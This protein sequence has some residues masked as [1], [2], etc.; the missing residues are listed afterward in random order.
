MLRTL[1][2]MGLFDRR[3]NKNSI[4]NYRE[5]LQEHQRAEAGIL[6]D[7]GALAYEK[8]DI[9]LSL[10]CLKKSFK[11]YQELVDAEK[12]ASILDI[13]GDIYYQIDDTQNALKYYKECFDLYSSMESPNKKNIYEKIVN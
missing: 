5:K 3:K 9:E 8:D 10:E 4:E 1:Q 2:I 11:I 13:I 7:M 12:E 6:L